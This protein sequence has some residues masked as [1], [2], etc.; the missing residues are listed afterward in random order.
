MVK[1]IKAYQCNTCEESYMKKDLAEICEKNHLNGDNLVVNDFFYKTAN[2][3]FPDQILIECN[4]YSGVLGLY[5]KI[6]EGSVEDFAY[7]YIR[8]N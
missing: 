6:E 2:E 8:E 3:M 4:N 7:L 5:K 1:I